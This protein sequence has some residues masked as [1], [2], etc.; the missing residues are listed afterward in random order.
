LSKDELIN[1]I[2]PKKYIFKQDDTNLIKINTD[3]IKI[4]ETIIV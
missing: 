3:Q 4:I 1:D 2:L